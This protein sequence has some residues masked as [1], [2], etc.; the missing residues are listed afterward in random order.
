MSLTS[1]LKNAAYDNAAYVARGNFTGI[2]TA[3]S[4]GVSTKFVAHANLLLFGLNA[5][6]TTAGTSTYTA[7]QYYLSLIHI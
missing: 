3:G 7:T 1:V 2:M 6:T 4:G 5:Y